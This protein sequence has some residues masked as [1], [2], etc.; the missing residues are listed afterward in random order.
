MFHVHVWTHNVLSA[1]RPSPIP[2]TL[3]SHPL[4]SS[5]S[6]RLTLLV[7]PRPPQ[8]QILYKQT[9]NM[10]SV[11]SASEPADMQKPDVEYFSE[12]SA[13]ES[14][15]MPKPDVEYFSEDS[16]SESASMPKPDVEYFF[17]DG[18]CTFLAEGVLFKLHKSFLSRDP[19]SMFRAMFSLP[20]GSTPDLSSQSPIA[21]TN[22]TAEE[23][24]ALCWVLYAL[25]TELRAQDTS[26]ANIQKLLNAAKMCHKYNVISFETWALDVIRN[27]CE[28]PS[29]DYLSFC[30]QIMLEGILELAILGA[31]EEL[32]RAVEKKWLYRLDTGDLPFNKALDFAESHDIWP[33]TGRIYYLLAKRIPNLRQSPAL[34]FSELQITQK[35]TLRLLSGHTSLVLFWESGLCQD[36]PLARPGCESHGTCQRVW[37]NRLFEVNKGSEVLRELERINEQFTRRFRNTFGLNLADMDI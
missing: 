27:Q 37:S 16:A 34:D 32:R 30:S 31:C 19:E 9:I 13:S 25:P 35:Q 7:Q 5:K 18:D 29:L 4:V 12:D 21:L 11:S 33:F 8:C 14:A 3:S 17:E 10:D 36:P 22:D 24:R 1:R 23:V 26:E 6:S 20:Q 2:L 15:G 28:S